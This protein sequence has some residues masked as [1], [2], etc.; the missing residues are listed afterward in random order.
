[1]HSPA[2]LNGENVIIFSSDDWSSG[3]KTSKYHIARQLARRNRVLFVNSVGLRAPTAGRRDIGRIFK[4]LGAFFR[5]AKAVPEGLHVYTPIVVPFCR[6][7]GPVRAVNAAVLRLSLRRLM[8]RLSL[9]DPIVF[10][11][12]PTF[13]DVIGALGEK[14]IVY[15][16]IDDLRGYAGVDGAWFDREEDRLL[17]RANCVISSAEELHREFVRK[18]AASHYVPHGVD[19]ALF[20]KAVTEDLP[21]P[22]DLRQI[23][24]PR[25]GFY[26]FLS[27][28][29]VDYPLL[30]RMAAARP[31][32]QVVLI[33][34]PRAGMDMDALLPEPNIHYLGLKPFEE[35]PAYTRHLDIGLI[36]FNR[37]Q[38]TLHS[39][40]LKLLEYLSGGLPV[41]STDIPE[42][43]RYGDAVHVAA[44]P[45]EFIVACE[46]ALREGDPAAREK[47]SRAAEAHSWEKRMEQISGIVH[48]EIERGDGARQA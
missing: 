3:L 9:K 37:N 25:L 32:W 21:L 39:N 33:G 35:L 4:K 48:A 10:A 16:C 14:A 46:R 13:N 36:P 23:P 38:L 11:F 43:R 5:G 44:S 31:E 6:G 15:Y 18:G 30:K 17:S 20:R 28:E 34:R 12:I 42:V 19:W 8:R 27:E 22:E 24:E 45:D 2:S 7:S 1:M 26:G 41:V 29:W 40:P 47:R